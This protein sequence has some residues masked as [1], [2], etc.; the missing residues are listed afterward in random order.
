MSLWWCRSRSIT[1]YLTLSFLFFLVDREQQVTIKAMSGEII[2][3][4]VKPRDS[5]KEV[6]IK[7]SETQGFLPSQQRLIFLLKK[8]E[9]HCTL[10]DYGV[11]EES[12]HY[13][14][15]HLV[16]RLRLP[17]KPPVV[18]GPL[19][20]RPIRE[21]D[22]GHVVQMDQSACSRRSCDLSIKF[23]IFLMTS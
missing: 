12:T 16:V 4:K 19:R 9:D 18:R 3:L 10:S 21:P 6:K 23:Q 7:I 5:V 1:R 13:S 17:Q 20:Y 11:N 14:L 15:V 22:L 8:L 2:M